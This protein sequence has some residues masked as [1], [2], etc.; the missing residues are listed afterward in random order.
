MERKGWRLI[1]AG[2]K[3]SYRRGR[4]T[5]ERVLDGPT[6]A[7]FHQWRKRVKDLWYHVCLLRPVWPQEMA[8]TA[9]ELKALG[10]TLG[11]DHDLV[12]LRQTLADKSAG[13]GE[14]AEEQDLE[15][16]I[17][18]RWQKLEAAALAVGGAVL[19]L[20]AVGVLRARAPLLAELA[21]RKAAARRTAAGPRAARPLKAGNHDCL[22]NTTMRLVL[23]PLKLLSTP[24]QL[25]VLVNF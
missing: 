23:V 16:S 10:R 9:A 2:L 25:A 14:F 11:G 17:G 18:R 20:N 12:V 4:R 24:Q 7:N 1:S 21:T 8:E 19:R 22:R 15:W 13:D 6:A 5:Y 3:R